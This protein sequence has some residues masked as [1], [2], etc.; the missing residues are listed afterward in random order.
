MENDLYSD[1][2]VGWPSYVD[3]L[4]TFVF[5]LFI[6]IGSL[7]YILS[8]DIQQRSFEKRIAPYVEDLRKAGIAHTVK[9]MQ[10]HI[11]LKGKVDFVT[12]NATLLPQHERFLRQVG[13]RL[14]KAPGARRI[15]IQGY[16]DKQPFPG[17]PFGNW[18]LSAQRALRV[19]EFFYQCRNCGYGAEVRNMLTL[20]GEGD[21]SAT[22][23]SNRQDRRVDVIIDFGEKRQ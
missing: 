23:G 3:F 17:D 10:V 16:A 14:G 1:E 8:G 6:F 5:V 4:S 2:S 21:T 7:L 19:Q 15:V 11:P 13:R 12:G 18:R 20:T 22:G 9:G